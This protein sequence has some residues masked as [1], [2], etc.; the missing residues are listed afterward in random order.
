VDFVVVAPVLATQTHPEVK[1]LGW[2]AFR[3]LVDIAN[4]PV[5]ALGGMQKKDQTIAQ[6]AGAQ[7]IAAI[8]C[9]VEQ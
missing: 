4:I 7:G 5:F 9:F 8:S 1:P 6:S 2:G 3:E